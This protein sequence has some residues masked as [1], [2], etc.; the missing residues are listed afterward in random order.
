MGGGVAGSGRGRGVCEEDGEGESLTF[1]LSHCSCHTKSG[2]EGRWE[3]R[4]IFPL[5]SKPSG[6]GA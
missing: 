4:Q 6:V 3:S 1:S 2:A 5:I